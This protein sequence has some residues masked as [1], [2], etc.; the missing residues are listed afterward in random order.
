[1]LCTKWSTGLQNALRLHHRPPMPHANVKIFPGSS[2]K[3]PQTRLFRTAKALECRRLRRPEF[4]QTPAAFPPPTHRFRAAPLR[5][6]TRINEAVVVPP[7]PTALFSSAVLTARSSITL[8]LPFG[9]RVN[10]AQEPLTLHHRPSLP[11]PMSFFFPPATVHCTCEPMSDPP[12]KVRAS[13]PEKSLLA[14]FPR[15]L[16]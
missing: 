5:G 15:L 3:A 9:E 10:F 1:M 7:L 11:L 2:L 16:T 14:H 8:N 4:G 12:A 13:E 6:S